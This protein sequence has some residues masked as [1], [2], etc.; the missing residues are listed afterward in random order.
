M[1]LYLCQSNPTSALSVFLNMFYS[2]PADEWS[3][4]TYKYL[5]PCKVNSL[6]FVSPGEA[7][8][9]RDAT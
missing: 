1:Y 3:S 8:I 7:S 2:R 5:W 9:H 4:E 6:C